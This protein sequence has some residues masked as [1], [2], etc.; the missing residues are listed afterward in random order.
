[1]VVN[2]LSPV[3]NVIGTGMLST[4]KKV[5]LEDLCFHLSLFFFFV[6]TCSLNSLFVSL[7]VCL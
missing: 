1:M 7:T 2:I 6:I 3:F 5:S 4:L